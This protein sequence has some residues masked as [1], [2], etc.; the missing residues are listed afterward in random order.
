MV[1]PHG[2]NAIV[3]A[4]GANAMIS[5]SDVQNAAPLLQDASIVMCQLEASMDAS[6]AAFTLAGKNRP[7]GALK[8]LNAAPI[9]TDPHDER[10]QEL[11]HACDVLCVNE[12]E[13]AQLLGW[14]SFRVLSGMG[15]EA[16]SA[17]LGIFPRT[18]SVVL[19][20]GERGVCLIERDILSGQVSET[21]TLAAVSCEAKDTVGA[22]DSFLGALAVA[23]FRG[24]TMRDA[25]SFATQIAGLS[26][27]FPGTQASY[28]AALDVFSARASTQGTQGRDSAPP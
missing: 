19:T 7:D 14:E 11:C 17:L 5:A 25:A 26:V 9:P 23:L 15:R 16:A 24:E 18:S 20:L 13:A 12:I 10:L 21:V 6:L 3:V 28:Y 2:A 1:D 4:P 8:I 27:Q 22:G